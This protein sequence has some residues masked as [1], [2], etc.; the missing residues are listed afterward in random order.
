M[1]FE[2]IFLP[3][4]FICCVSFFFWLLKYPKELLGALLFR[5][6]RAPVDIAVSLCSWFFVAMQSWFLMTV[7]TMLKG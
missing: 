6:G 4:G 2:S 5:H 1:S 7:F 3:G